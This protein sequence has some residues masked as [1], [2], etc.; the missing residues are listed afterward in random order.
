MIAINLNDSPE[1]ITKYVTA[2]KFTFLLGMCREDDL[3]WKNY[4]VVGCPTNYLLDSEGKVVWRKAGFVEKEVR[5]A[6]KELGLE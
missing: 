2:N 5:G 3:V 6:L 1:T 4:G